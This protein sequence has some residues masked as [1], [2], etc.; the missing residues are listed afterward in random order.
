MLSNLDINNF[1]VNH[2]PARTAGSVGILVEHEIVLHDQGVVVCL[3]RDGH[4]R[5]EWVGSEYFQEL[6]LRS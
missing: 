5:E 1:Y 4:E 6:K 3:I 2:G